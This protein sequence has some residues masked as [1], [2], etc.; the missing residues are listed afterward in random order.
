MRNYQFILVLLTFSYL[1]CS[2]SESQEEAITTSQISNSERMETITL[3]LADLIDSTTL[4][5]Q[6]ITIQSDI[7]FKQAKRF[8]GYA[9]KDLLSA[10]L[11][12]FEDTTDIIMTYHCTDGYK[13]TMSISRLFEQNAYLI[14][15][16]LDA[17][18][19]SNWTNEWSKKMS[20]YY[21]VWDVDTTIAYNY[22]W[23]Y[24]VFELSFSDFD[25][26]FA[27]IYPEDNELAQAGFTQFKQKCLKCHKINQ[28]GGNMGPEFNYPKNITSYWQKEDIY[29]FALNPQSYRISSSMAAI[30]HLSRE[31]FNLIYTYLEYMKD[32][33]EL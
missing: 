15:K 4:D 29:Q 23:P 17:P 7:V 22:P 9:L 20:P 32:K 31:E 12:M 10:T 33:K 25:Q 19:G 3:D 28:I 1:S 6:Q 30:P 16:D 8:E 21:V 13:P 11:A 2:P 5:L 26:Q 14:T 18:Q 24:G 27:P